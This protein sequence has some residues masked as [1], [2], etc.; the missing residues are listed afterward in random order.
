V[1]VIVGVSL[2]HDSLHLGQIFEF[3]GV[4]GST[5][6]KPFGL[7]T[8]L[9]QKRQTIDT[10]FVVAFKYKNVAMDNGLLLITV[11]EPE[12]CRSLHSARDR[13]YKAVEGGAI[14]ASC[15][16]VSGRNKVK[17]FKCRFEWDKGKIG[18]IDGVGKKWR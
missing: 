12:S 11:R 3:G 2:L 16:A 10:K 4:F 17:S 13:A 7:L 15:Y 14:S 6:P 5:V 18:C 9:G 1:A 8:I